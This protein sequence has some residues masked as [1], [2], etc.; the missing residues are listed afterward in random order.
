MTI[1]WKPDAVAGAS[2]DQIVIGESE[3]ICRV[4]EL[5]RQVAAS[6]ASVMITGPSGSGK[7]IVANAIH[8]ESLRAR[9]RFIAVNCGAIPRDLLESELFGHEKGSFT[10]AI[11]QRRGR[12]EDAHKGTLFL[13]EIGDMPPEM[14]VKLLRV[15]ESRQVERVGGSGSIDVDT[16][17]ISATHQNLED[18]I[19]RGLFREDLFYRLGVFPIQLPPLKDR[20]EDIAPLIKFF[21]RRMCAPDTVLGFTPG[22]M[23]RLLMH[24]WRGN[25]RE[26]RNVV[27]RAIILFPNMQ[28]S[29][30]QVDTLFRRRYSNAPTTQ[31]AAEPSRYSATTSDCALD[32]KGIDLK[33]HLADIERQYIEA[34]L[35]KAEGVIADAARLLSMQRT[36][37]IEKMK[38]L[39]VQKEVRLVA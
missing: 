35:A 34:A 38:R 37:F 1:S 9:N 30:D 26:L 7:E 8:H 11:A 12:F 10:G 39:D 15:L 32:D 3:A 20:P 14:Q 25:V 19:E 22:A 17:I 4:R 24:E 18:R 28:I 33:Q 36:T 31:S 13:D 16:R 27:E 5:I 23:A 21:L 29:S 6:D 2:L